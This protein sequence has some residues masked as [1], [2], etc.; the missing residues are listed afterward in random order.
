MVT[1]IL[2]KFH[3]AL[4]MKGVKIRYETPWIA[5]WF[6]SSHTGTLFNLPFVEYKSKVVSKGVVVSSEVSIF[7]DT[8]VLLSPEVVKSSLVGI[9]KF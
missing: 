4:D 8:R 9:I 5:F 6:I 7:V 1:S 2:F 3:S